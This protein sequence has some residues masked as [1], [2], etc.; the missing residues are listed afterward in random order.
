MRVAFY[1]H[2]PNRLPASHEGNNPYGTLLSDALHRIGVEVEYEMDYSQDYLRKNQ[3]RVHVLHFHWPH[4]DYYNDDIRIMQR[5][6]RKMLDSLKLAR[7]LGYK[8]VWTAHN[9]Y[10][11]NR[12]HQGIDHKFRLHLCQLCTSIIAHCEA[13]AAEV[14]Q[15]FDRTHDLFVIPHGHFIGV[16]P[17]NVSRTQARSSLGIPSQDFAYGFIGGIL[18]YKGL[19][20]LIETF[21][22]IQRTDSWLLIAGGGRQ[23]EYL[24]SIRNLTF[25]HPRI[26]SRIVQPRVS[27]L[28]LMLVLRASNT[29]VLP[30]LATMSSGTVTLALSEARPVIAPSMGCLP[31]TILPGGGLLYDPNQPDALLESMEQIRSWDLEDASR[32]ALASIQRFDWNQIA[33]LTL[34]AY[35]R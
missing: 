28:D 5:Q 1:Y 33:E 35:K 32:T 24:N 7:E 23:E 17:G 2:Q 19:E 8:V 18:P 26:L 34:E 21:T 4:H 6:M 14:K 27:T 30:F 9:I 15:Q 12:T 29:I 3:G 13:S 10:P 20:K 22:R 25:R 16:Y 11:H 31:A